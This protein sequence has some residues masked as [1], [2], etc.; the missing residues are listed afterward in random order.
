MKYEIGGLGFKSKK[1]IIGHVQRIMKKY[2]DYRKIPASDRSFMIALLQRHQYADQK[3]GVG[4][5]KMWI[6]PNGVYNTRGFWLE[7]VDGTK[8]DFSF[9]QCLNP[10]T[11]L[12]DFKQACRIAVASSIEE[13][14]ESEFGN[15]GG[16]C[17]V[18]GRVMTPDTCHVDH[19]PPNTFEVIVTDYIREREI[20]V[21]TAPLL[22]HR[23]G[24]I[25]NRFTDDGFQED[26]VQYHN[27]K[28][29][30]RLISAEA[31]LKKL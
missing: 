8:T 27:N 26:W 3:I 15:T 16:V 20:D 9:Y 19:C 22:E 6:Q 29:E 10:S 30:L 25:G 7:R 31:N 4:V 14:K 1:A 12:S 23:D 28:A 18:L 2:G 21:E 13:F 17:P 5:K 24:K 11:P